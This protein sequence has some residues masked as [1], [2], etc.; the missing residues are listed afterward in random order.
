MAGP[1]IIYRVQKQIPL[2]SETVFMSPLFLFH[3]WCFSTRL[4]HYCQA[5]A[6]IPRVYIVLDLYLFTHPQLQVTTS[7]F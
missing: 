2:P 1:S 7:D 5:L 3:F 6:W 4:L